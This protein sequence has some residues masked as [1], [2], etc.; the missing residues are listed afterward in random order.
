MIRVYLGW[1]PP[2]P[3][4]P[5][6]PAVACCPLRKS[7]R[8]EQFAYKQSPMDHSKDIAES[9]IQLNSLK[10]IVVPRL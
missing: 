7:T 8:T 4:T 1:L 9:P 3:S 2:R 10:E 5:L 6:L